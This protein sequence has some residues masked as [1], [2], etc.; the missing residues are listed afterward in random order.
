M[1]KVLQEKG[2]AVD[3]AAAELAGL[4]LGQSSTSPALVAPP[5]PAAPPVADDYDSVEEEDDDNPFGDANALES[6]ALE[7]DEPKW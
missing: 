3:G 2:K 1:L 7:R 6:P 4:K 5:R